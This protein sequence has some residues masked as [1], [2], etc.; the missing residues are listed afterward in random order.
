LLSNLFLLAGMALLYKFVRELTKDQDVARRT[1]L[2]MLVFPTAFFFSA[3]YTESMLLF[4]SVAVF[5]A[6]WKRNWM[7]AGMMGFFMALSRPVGLLALPAVG[8]MY[9]ESIEWKF[10]HLRPNVLW[11]GL[12][13]AGLLTFLLITYPVSGDLLAPFHVQAAWGRGFTWPWVTLFNPN[14]VDA[15]I[16]ELDWFSTVGFV[17]LGVAALF[18]LKSKG[19]G[20]Y[21]LL[22]YVPVLTSGTLLSAT[23]FSV[24][25]FPAFILMAMAGRRNWLNQTLVFLFFALQVLLM[26]AWSQ[27]YWVG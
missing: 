9:M 16:T 13:P 4:F 5:Y 23:R 6:A 22:T 8:W 19:F 18:S 10:K 7:M 25:V 26:A 27:F 17:L 3:V 14:N 20:I 1:I 11:L 2:Y 24:L 15:Y 21:A 12:I